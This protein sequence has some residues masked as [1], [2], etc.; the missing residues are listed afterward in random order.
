MPPESRSRP[1]KRPG[2]FG[3]LI[4][5]YILVG[6]KPGIFPSEESARVRNPSEEY[7]FLGR[8]PQESENHY[9]IPVSDAILSS[10]GT[11]LQ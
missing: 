8:P 11:K 3:N 1:L 7:S 6:T 2:N 5:T 9:G 4:G 10:G